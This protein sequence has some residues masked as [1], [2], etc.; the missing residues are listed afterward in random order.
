MAKKENVKNRLKRFK[1][2]YFSLC[3]V[4]PMSHEDNLQEKSEIY[5]KITWK[6]KFCEPNPDFIVL[7]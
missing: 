5:S 6:K 2:I 3:G 1:K 7:K 4:P